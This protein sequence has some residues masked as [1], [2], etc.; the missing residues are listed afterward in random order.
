MPQLPARDC[1]S[2][3]PL[4]FHRKISPGDL[5]MKMLR[6][7][8]LLV[9]S[10]IV[11]AGNSIAKDRPNYD[12]LANSNASKDLSPEAKDKA[13]KL[14]KHAA[15]MQMEKRL[16]VPS[17]LF[18]NAAS[19]ENKSQ[20]TGSTPEEAAAR[21]HMARFA[22]LYHLD[23]YDISTCEVKGIHNTGR[24][25][26][27]VQMR[28]RIDGVEVFRDEMKIVMNQ[29]LELVAMS[30]YIPTW[31][32]SRTGAF[33]LGP[34]QA[35]ALAFQDLTDAQ[36]ETPSL[37]WRATRDGF[38]FFTL[39][40]QTESGINLHMVEPSRVKQVMFNL[41]EGL[42][43]AYYLELN[44]SSPDST[45]SDFYSYVISAVDGKLLF[46]NNLTSQ[47]SFS[48]RVWAD[49]SGKFVPFDGPQGT[50]GTPHPTGVPDGFQ[51]AFVP[52][53]LITLQNS[54]FSK[55]DPWLPPG[56]TQTIGNNV[57]A[58]AD[59]VAPDGFTAAGDFHADIT[60][61]NSFDYTY[62]TALGP[63][64][65]LNQQKAAIVQLF[66]MNNFLHDWYYD[67]GFDEAAGNAQTNN[68]GRGGVQNDNIRAEGQDF[69]GRN[70]ANMS[71]PADGGR[72][73]LQMFV[74]DG[75]AA[76]ALTANAPTAIAR[77]Y[78]NGVAAFGPLAFDTTAPVVQANPPDGCLA[79]T[80]PA[81]V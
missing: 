42:E 69:S 27:V 21:G 17:F 32:K 77:T 72:P 51:A 34:T 45:D 11:F 73:R 33:T 68:F 9:V 75:N 20:G 31:T 40:T 52:P 61:P 39:D 26:V 50:T 59:L 66:F 38:D 58:Y 71:T 28:Q 41:P 24:G 4:T 6:L 74:F 36:I 47:D 37:E 64:T 55:N 19:A 16:G 46:R 65:S 25:A 57:E 53:Q 63:Q 79:F 10:A 70:N 49:S 13:E 2:P 3:G 7:V 62:N 78:P 81:D 48:Y 23:E 44:V 1:A 35:V 80:N 12:A 60:S 15:T 56:A 18:A 30:G 22:E 29:K 5:P 76:H 43:P 54:P 14:V 67:S 8:A